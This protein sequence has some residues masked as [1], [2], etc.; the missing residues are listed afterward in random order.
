MVQRIYQLIDS[1]NPNI[2]IAEESI[3]N[4]NA[5]VHRMLTMILGTIYGECLRKK[6]D[7][8]FLR[9]TTW[10]SLIRLE[11][12]KLPRKRDDL[13]KWSLQKVN[14]LFGVIDVDDNVSDAILIGCAFLNKEK[15]DV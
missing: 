4:K 14:E 6:I 15:K 2:V 12:E 7:Y 11:G 8:R 1:E 3:M 9:P 5:E 10:R 13:K